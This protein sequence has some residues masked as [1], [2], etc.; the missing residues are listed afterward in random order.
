M[1]EPATPASAAI[2][3]GGA[4]GYLRIATE[5]AFAPRAMFAGYRKLLAKGTPHDPGFESLW[6]F[7]LGSP[8]ARATLRAMPH[9]SSVWVSLVR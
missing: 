4:P 8:S 5:E 2:P 1:N 3:R 7:Y 9:A 6:G